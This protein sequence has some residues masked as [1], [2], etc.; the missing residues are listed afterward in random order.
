MDERAFH[1]HHTGVA[2]R[3]LEQDAEWFSMLGYTAEGPRFAD[4]L[5]GIIGQFMVLG[6]SRIELLEPLPDSHVLDNWLARGS[7][8]YHFGFEVANLQ[9]SLDALSAQ[10]AKLVSDP[11]PAVAF[12]GR[13]VAF[14]MRRN[15]TLI[16]LI[17]SHLT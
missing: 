11:K 13:Q 6:A 2:C 15:R 8:I 12:G 3:S 17:E 16:E 10:G 1:F 7:P 14:C 4:P 5:Q 9:Q